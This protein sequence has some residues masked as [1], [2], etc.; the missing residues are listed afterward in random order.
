MKGNLLIKIGLL[1][2]GAIFILVYM[3]AQLGAFSRFTQ[4]INEYTVRFDSVSGLSPGARVLIAGVEVGEVKEIK[5]D[6]GRAKLVLALQSQV[7][8]HT[9]A[10]ALLRTQG[11][12]GER[13]VEIQPGQTALLLPGQEIQKSSLLLDLDRFLDQV[14]ALSASVGDFSNSFNRVFGGSEGQ[15]R[16]K[17]MVEDLD[18]L[19]VLVKNFNQSEGTLKKLIDEP[20]AYDKLVQAL[21]S[22]TQFV[23]R[24]EKMNLVLSYRV[25]FLWA[26]PTGDSGFRNALA[27]RMQMRPERFYLAELIELPNQD[28]KVSLQLGLNFGNL[29]LRGGL[30]ESTIGA[31]AELKLSDRL[32]LGIEAFDFTRTVGPHLRLQAGFDLVALFVAAGYDDA[33]LPQKP[34]SFYISLGVRLTD[35]DLRYLLGLLAIKL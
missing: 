21:T 8:L 4:S 26:K 12:L 25:N 20:L 6:S 30:I 19:G 18:A 9:D 28:W 27:A 17:R 2:L 33:L 34:G 29:S 7:R 32:R 16:L 22:A 15:E 10:I 5:L 13:Y 23:E 14:G 3:L 24:F 31:G 35:E 11:L 1:L